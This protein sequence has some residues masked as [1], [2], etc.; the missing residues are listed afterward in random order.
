MNM[1]NAKQARQEFQNDYDKKEKEIRK[2]LKKIETGLEKHNR[3][4]A[5]NDINWGYIGNLGYMVEQLTNV[6]DFVNETGEYAK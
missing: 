3:K 5:Q 2:L 1:K 4:V 6:S